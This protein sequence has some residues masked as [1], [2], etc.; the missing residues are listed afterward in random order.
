MPRVSRTTNTGLLALAVAFSAGVHAWLVPEHLEEIPRL[1]YAFV[2]PAA[3]G[4]LIA[5]AV[6]GRPDDGRL[7]L[8]WSRRRP[9]RW[10]WRSRCP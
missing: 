5:V 8:P 1:G 9:R 6:V 2:A 7:R 4:G 10:E 3:T